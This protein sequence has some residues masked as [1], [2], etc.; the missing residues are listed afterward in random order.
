MSEFENNCFLYLKTT[1]VLHC[2]ALQWVFFLQLL[3]LASDLKALRFPLVEKHVGRG[4][5]H[6]KDRSF[7]HFCS[8][9]DTSHRETDLTERDLFH[10]R[11][12]S[13]KPSVSTFASQ[14]T[15]PGLGKTQDHT[16][17]TSWQTCRWHNAQ[18]GS[19]PCAPRLLSADTAEKVIQNIL[20]LNLTWSTKHHDNLLIHCSEKGPYFRYWVPIGTCLTFW[21]PISVF[22]ILQTGSF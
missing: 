17:A 16:F 22:L 11:V 1:S 13:V 15:A 9:R 8:L 20:W 5:T 18:S 12:G 6:L 7:E 10:S 4:P 14:W 3:R 19:H 2:I 21:V